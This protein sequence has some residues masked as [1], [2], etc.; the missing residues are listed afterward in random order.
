VI[1]AIESSERGPAEGA[2]R[3]HDPRL[4]PRFESRK[5]R[6]C[7]GLAGG[8]KGCMYDETATGL[9]AGMGTSTSGPSPP[10]CGC[11]SGHIS[12]APP[13]GKG[14][15]SMREE[16]GFRVS[17][18]K[19]RQKKRAIKAA[20]RQQRASAEGRRRHYRTFVK[21]KCAC[22]RHGGILKVGDECVFRHTPREILC[23]RCAD[24]LGID[25]RLSAKWEARSRAKQEKRARREASRPRPEIEGV[26]LSRSVPRP[27][28]RTRAES[29][30]GP[31]L[32]LLEVLPT[33]A[34]EAA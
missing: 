14:C 20:Q 13:P 2:A 10:L 22:N 11:E 6:G 19:S 29:G 12:T 5:C 33:D 21:R 26:P 9:R 15:P 4:Q 18:F 25:Y 24:E 7:R 32:P 17:S 34:R 16:R 8:D 3:R 23:V 27:S 31:Q 28:Q 1:D 30:G